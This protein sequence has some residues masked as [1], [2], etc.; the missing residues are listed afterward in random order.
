MDRSKKGEPDEY[1]GRKPDSPFM[2]NIAFGRGG[3][4]LKLRPGK[5][6]RTRAGPY[7][8]RAFRN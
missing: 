6:K 2:K 4:I 1:A 5:K 8:L 7:L 3:A